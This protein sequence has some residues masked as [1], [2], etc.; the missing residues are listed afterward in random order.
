[1]TA[2][3]DGL[4]ARPVRQELMSSGGRKR[5]LADRRGVRNFPLWNPRGSDGSDSR[6]TYRMDASQRAMRGSS[7]DLERSYYSQLAGRTIV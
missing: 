6:H 1:M 3:V 4:Q 5:E 2:L 7:K